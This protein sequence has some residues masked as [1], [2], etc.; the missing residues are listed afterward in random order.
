MRNAAKEICQGKHLP[1]C[2]TSASVSVEKARDQLWWW[3][4]WIVIIWSGKTVHTII[5]QSTGPLFVAMW[6]PVGAGHLLGQCKYKCPRAN[7]QMSERV[8][9]L[10]M[11]LKWPRSMYHPSS[12]IHW[13]FCGQRLETHSHSQLNWVLSMLPLNLSVTYGYSGPWKL[14]QSP[15]E[16]E[17]L[18]QRTSNE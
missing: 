10:D 7:V 5:L 14:A 4:P 3:L 15:R 17:F 18:S 2:V 9:S 1:T 11:W 6:Y 13:V 16:W 12:D 8:S